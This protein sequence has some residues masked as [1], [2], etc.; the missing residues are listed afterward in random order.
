[1]RAITV[2]PRPVGTTIRLE[3]LRAVAAKSNWKSRFS[4]VCGNRCG[5]S[6]KEDIR[7]PLPLVVFDGID[8]HLLFVIY[9]LNYT[10]HPSMAGDLFPSRVMTTSIL[11]VLKDK[12]I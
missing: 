10:N 11:A 6:R 7:Y 5:C 2:L 9:H 3:D 12:F 8:M 4:T 1:M